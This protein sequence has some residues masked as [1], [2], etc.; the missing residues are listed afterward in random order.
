MLLSL[1]PV[2]IEV[3]GVLLLQCRRLGM[4]MRSR[5]WPNSDSGEERIVKGRFS[6]EKDS[7]QVQC[8]LYAQVHAFPASARREVVIA[9]KEDPI[10]AI[11]FERSIR[12][13]YPLVS[14][15][16]RCMP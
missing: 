9:T 10:R 6:Q 13:H 7:R 12:G 2:E 3:L 11:R 5:E 4:R 16:S 8:T 1:S 15:D 14:N